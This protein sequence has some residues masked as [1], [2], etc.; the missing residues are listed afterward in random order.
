[1]VGG[2]QVVPTADAVQP[3]AGQAS[4]AGGFDAWEGPE[5]ESVPE[6][7]PAAVVADIDVVRHPLA[8]PLDALT[9][10]VEALGVRVAELSRLR[11]RDAALV[12]RLHADNTALRT[13]EIVAAMAPL[14]AGLLRLHDQMASLAAGDPD[15]DAGMLRN[16]LVQLLDTAAGV[17]AYAP[18]VG[19]PFDASRHSGA[20]R[21]PT[22]DPGL[23]G[24]VHRV[25][26][27]GFARLDGSLVRVAEV[28][29]NRFVAAARPPSEPAAP[30]VSWGTAHPIEEQTP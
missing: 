26:K 19:E 1:V 22:A 18:A 11:D 8:E 21:V 9:E 27:P 17:T 3:P 23:D 14:M 5:P 20:G 2:P 4:S 28:E 30:A 7:L 16:Q 15:S 12:E 24:T 6:P 10:A 13:G 29:V 25:V